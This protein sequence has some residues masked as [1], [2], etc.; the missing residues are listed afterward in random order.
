[1]HGRNYMKWWLGAACCGVALLIALIL[2]I[3][4]GLELRDV[5][6]AQ[7][8][9][10]QRLATLQARK[11]YPAESNVE[12]LKEKAEALEFHVGELSAELGR[13]TYAQENLEAAAFSA[14]VQDILERMRK[15]AE[16]TGV[17]IPPGMEASFA[18]YASGGAIPRGEHVPRL[19]RQLQ[20]VERIGEVLIHSG[21]DS[22]LSLTRDRFE[23]PAA[24]PKEKVRRAPRRRW[25]RNEVEESDVSFETASA[26]H[27]QGWY[28]AERVGVMFSATQ[29]SVWR[30]LNRLASTPRFMAVAEFSHITQTRIVDYDPESVVRGEE[31][32]DEMLRFLSEGILV[33]SEALS[34]PERIISGEELVEVSLLVDVYRFEEFEP[35]EEQP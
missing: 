16:R 31:A 15:R 5:R 34:R 7:E 8:R 3:R 4:S 23:F 28:S 6:R 24:V 33:G 32:D 30:V 25:R 22:I 20:A 9:S 21:V 27:P 11:P 13:D 29:E 10:H 35:A 19:V 2:L 1:M 17:G 14:R 26:A 12:A 18:R